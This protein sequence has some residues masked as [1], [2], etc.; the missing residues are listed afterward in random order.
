MVKLVKPSIEYKNS[1]IEAIKEFQAEGRNIKVDLNE[2][3]NNFSGY[4][5]KLRNQAKGI[6]LPKDY[7]PSSIYWLVD[8]KDYIGKVSVRHRLTPA[9]LKIGGHIG[10]EIR[11]SKRKMG[12]GTLALKSALPKAKELGIDKALLTCNVDNIGSQK[13]I[14]KNGGVLENILE[15][16]GQVKRRY[17]IDIK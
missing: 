17:W 9:L 15:T 4:V 10:Y 5:L 12:Y 6:D 3:K 7:V 11:P 16:E 2:L 14:E 13:I 8:G 1:F